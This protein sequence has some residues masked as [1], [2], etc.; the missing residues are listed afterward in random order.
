MSPRELRQAYSSDDRLFTGRFFS[1][2]PLDVGPADHVGIVLVVP[3]APES[4]AEVFPYLYRRLLTPVKGRGWRMLWR[5]HLGAFVRARMSAKKLVSEYDA[6]GGGKAINRFNREQADAL[7]KAVEDRYDAK[8]SVYLASPFGTPDILTSARRMEED[9]VTHVVL[10]PLF[11]QY[12]SD[13]TGRA[14]AEWEVLVQQGTLARRQTVAIREF[15]THPLYVRA[16]NERVDQALQRFPKH[17]RGQVELMFA[18]H[19]Q[20]VPGGQGHIPDPYCCLAHN[21]VDELMKLRGQDLAYS[22]AFVRPH[23]W[24]SRLSPDIPQQFR[25]LASA[26]R[27]SVLVVPVDHVTEQ[28]DTAFLLDVR[29]RQSADECGI[30][31]Y[32]VVSGINCHPL[33]IEAMTD[34][35]DAALGAR[36]RNLPTMECLDHCPRPD[37]Q[38]STPDIRCTA[39]PW[40]RGGKRPA[41]ERPSQIHSGHAVVDQVSSPVSSDEK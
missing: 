29:M 5:S 31:H 27:R 21:T 13:S 16:L 41:E 37:W 14:L 38:G 34:M 10:M 2:G 17:V 32:H 25:E 35:A 30:S 33:F 28:F 12:A 18:A 39:C 7:T 36:P 9:G 19:G 15:A 26:G 3:G 4:Q 40:G 1:S 20:A 6:I 23:A 24:G 8:A 22:L 11:P